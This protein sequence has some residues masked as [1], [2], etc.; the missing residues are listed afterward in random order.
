MKTSFSYADFTFQ[1][2]SYTADVGFSL[3]QNPPIA[4]RERLRHRHW[5]MAG[6]L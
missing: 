6:Y 1:R 5:E 4:S 3:S 2:R